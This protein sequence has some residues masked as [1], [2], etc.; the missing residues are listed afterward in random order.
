MTEMLSRKFDKS[1]LEEEKAG[2]G[3]LRYTKSIIVN[4]YGN[5]T[6]LGYMAPR[7]CV[8]FRLLERKALLNN[9]KTT[10]CPCQIDS[11]LDGKG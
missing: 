9:E 10:S 5:V 3:H 1:D 6:T 7:S 2:Q 11:N 4:V 8:Q